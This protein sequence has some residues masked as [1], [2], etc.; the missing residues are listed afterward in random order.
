MVFLFRASQTHKVV[1]SLFDDFLGRRICSRVVTLSS[2][3][4]VMSRKRLVEKQKA[5]FSGLVWRPGAADWAVGICLASDF[6]SS[7]KLKQ[8]SVTRV[9]GLARKGTCCQHSGWPGTNV[10][11]FHWYDENRSQFDVPCA[12]LFRFTR[13]VSCQ[14]PTRNSEG[15]RNGAS[16]EK[17]GHQRKDTPTF[18]SRGSTA[19]YYG[20]TTTKKKQTNKHLSVSRF[21]SATHLLQF[22]VTRFSHVLWYPNSVGLNTQCSALRKWGESGSFNTRWTIWAVPLSKTS[23]QSKNKKKTTQNQRASESLQDA[24]QQAL[25]G[26]SLL[27]PSYFMLNYGIT[28]CV[29]ESV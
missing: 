4:R 29:C 28:V 25:F 26:L 3:T 18:G 21:A 12:V 1:P 24:G 20:L 22:A 5:Y 10:I 13:G 15:K 2:G 23:E 14:P 7:R 8:N 16:S 17:H 9:P 11:R 27:W 6:I 19:C